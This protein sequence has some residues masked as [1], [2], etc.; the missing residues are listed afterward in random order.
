MVDL[1]VDRPHRSLAPALI[2]VRTALAHVRTACDFAYGFPNGKSS[3]VMLRCGYRKVGM[4]ARYACVLRFGPYLGRFLSLPVD[5]VRQAYLTARRW[6]AASTFRLEWAGD[7][8]ASFDDLWASARPGRGLVGVRSSAFLRW[9]FLEN[10]VGS[11]RVA[12]LVRRRDGKLRG[13]AVIQRVENVAHIRDVFAHE[14]ELGPLLDLLLPSLLESGCASASF[15]FLGRRSVVETFR[16]HR[17]ALR[18]ADHDVVAFGTDE[19]AEAWYLTDAD[20][21][22]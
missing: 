7:V 9:R 10:P 11:F 3:G 19:E 8:D 4:F 6:P 18:E 1:A 13:Y 22:A 2:L 16:A 15:C 12:R 14:G 21:D 5:L 17:F 20:V